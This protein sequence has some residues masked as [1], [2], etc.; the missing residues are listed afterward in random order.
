M[1]P[2]DDNFTFFLKNF[3]RS[4]SFWLVLGCN[5]FGSTLF[6]G[7]D[8][9]MDLPRRIN[10]IRIILWSYSVNVMSNLFVPCVYKGDGRWR[11]F[12]LICKIGRAHV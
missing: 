6:G 3:Y 1:E 2:L 7:E 11:C 4:W 12:L 5:I 8:T 10:P 9:S